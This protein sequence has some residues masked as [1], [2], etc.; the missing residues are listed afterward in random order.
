MGPRPYERL[1]F[2]PKRQRSRCRTRS[3][4]R[5]THCARFYSRF[6]PPRKIL[7]FATTPTKLTIGIPTA[8]PRL[9]LPSFIPA[10][11]SPAYPRS[12]SLSR[13]CCVKRYGLVVAVETCPQLKRHSIRTYPIFSLKDSEFYLTKFGIRAK[14]HP[15]LLNS[16]RLPWLYSLVLTRALSTKNFHG[17]LSP[18]RVL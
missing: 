16:P 2:F 7:S 11:P 8:Y 12:L 13:L 6:F 5:V 3:G 10:S 4:L 9:Y 17:L 15:T 1:L 14:H 18:Q